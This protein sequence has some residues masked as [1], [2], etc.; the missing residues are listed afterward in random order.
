M[1]IIKGKVVDVQ[2][3]GIIIIVENED[4][5]HVF[6]D[7]N[8]A[9]EESFDVKIGDKIDMPTDNSS[10]GY[11]TDDDQNNVFISQEKITIN[12]KTYTV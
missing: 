7:I 4:G 1:P 2:N 6:C 10:A 8:D 3:N 5:K 9:W 11:Y 12:G